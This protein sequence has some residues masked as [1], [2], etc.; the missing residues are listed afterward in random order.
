MSQQPAHHPYP[1]WLARLEAP[2]RRMLYNPR[3]ILSRHVVEGM[4][5]I[6]PGPAMG[7]FT[8]ELARLV[9]P[10]GR[11]IALDIQ[12]A[13]LT[14]LRRRAR[15]HG[16]HGRLD[17]RLVEPDRLHLEDVTA[18]ADFVLAFAVV[19]EVADPAAFFS[20]CFA[21]LKPGAMMLLGEPAGHVSE[22]EYRAEIAAA[23]SAGFRP[24]GSP[25]VPKNR[26]ALLVKQ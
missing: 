9:G 19:H 4:T 7:F 22:Q 13:M 21:A 26:A 14:V 3:E 16:L 1:A 17:L 12:P 10:R 18:T 25:A 6:E 5:V 2:L 11:V 15:R 8:L 23:F 24:C 20:E